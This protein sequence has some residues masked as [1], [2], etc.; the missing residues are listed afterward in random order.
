MFL[1]PDPDQRDID[2][3]AIYRMTIISILGIVILWCAARFAFA[4]QYRIAR[5]RNHIGDLFRRGI[6]IVIV[7]VWV[8][9][10]LI[11]IISLIGKHQADKAVTQRH[12]KLFEKEENDEENETTNNGKTENK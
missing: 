9:L 5:L 12:R 1:P 3:Q 10:W 6:I 8:S 11:G 4:T 2:K 7:I